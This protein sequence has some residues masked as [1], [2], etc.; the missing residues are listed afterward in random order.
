MNIII[1]I[2][3][4]L[5]KNTLAPSHAGILRGELGCAHSLL[6]GRF[7]RAMLKPLSHRQYSPAR[8][9]AP[10]QTSLR[11]SL[12]WWAVALGNPSPRVVPLKP[13]RPGVA[14]SD[15]CGDGR[16]G[17]VLCAPRGVVTHCR[18]PL[19]MR[20]EEKGSAFTS[21]NFPMCSSLYS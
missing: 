6:F 12:Q 9:R 8:K 10:L 14:Y 21:G 16:L 3:E 13:A 20:E 1:E 4:I 2:D 17:D 18:A 5:K 7:G 19:W 15:A 11:D